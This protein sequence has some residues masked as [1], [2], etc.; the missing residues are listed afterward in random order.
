MQDKKPIDFYSRKFNTAHKQNITNERELLSAI[1]T[2]KEYKLIFL[3]NNCSML[4]GQLQFYDFFRLF[5]ELDL[6]CQ[7]GT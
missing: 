5:L 3:G 6:E 1:E 2:Y 7:T 4:N